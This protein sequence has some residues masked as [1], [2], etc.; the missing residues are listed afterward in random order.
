MN[1]LPS[2]ENSVP[3]NHS[4]QA[5]PPAGRRTWPR[6]LGLGG[7]AAVALTGALVGGNLPRLRQQNKLD[8]EVA[9]AAAQ[10]PRVTVAVA[11]LIGQAP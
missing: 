3:A 4:A 2:V 11:K 7:L 8:A 6:V 1:T 10:P 5:Q 9:Q